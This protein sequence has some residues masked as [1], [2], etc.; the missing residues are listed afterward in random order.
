MLL[1]KFDFV[2]FVPPCHINLTFNFI[3]KKFNRYTKLCNK[4]YHVIKGCIIEEE[5]QCIDLGSITIR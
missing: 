4:I 5:S 2:D 1:L 3:L